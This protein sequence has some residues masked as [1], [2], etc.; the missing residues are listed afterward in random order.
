M[1][2]LAG[3]EKRIGGDVDFRHL[4]G[5]PDGKPLPEGEAG[6]FADTAF[7]CGGPLPLLFQIRS[8]GR[9]GVVSQDDRSRLSHA[10]PHS[11]RQPPF[12]SVPAKKMWSASS[13]F[14]RE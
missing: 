5:D 1:G 7:T 3:P 14:T 4:A 6:Q 10:K 12:R 8:Q 13:S 2:H 11:V 9:Y